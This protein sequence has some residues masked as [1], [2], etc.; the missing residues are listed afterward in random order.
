MEDDRKLN[1]KFKDAEVSLRLQ[2]HQDKY[3]GSDEPS[4]FYR[5]FLVVRY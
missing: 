5:Q 4:N 2:N 3:P 1:A